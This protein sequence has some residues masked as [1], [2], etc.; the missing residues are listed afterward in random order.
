MTNQDVVGYIINHWRME[1]PVSRIVVHMICLGHPL[2]RE[3]ILSV[4]KRYC[5]TQSENSTYVTKAKR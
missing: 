2:S 5:D 1:S 4:V 3:T